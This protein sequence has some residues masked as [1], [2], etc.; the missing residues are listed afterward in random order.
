MVQ[1]SLGSTDTYS[2]LTLK[3][4]FTLSSKIE[5]GKKNVVV[6]SHTSYTFEFEH[7]TSSSNLEG[8]LTLIGM[9]EGTFHPLSFLDQILPAEFLSKISKPEVKIDT[10]W[11]NLT[12][13]Q[14]H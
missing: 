8:T 9:R 10:N 2:N 12:P 11:V 7:A 4:K 6:Y 13:C 1:N 14:A 3:S 5:D